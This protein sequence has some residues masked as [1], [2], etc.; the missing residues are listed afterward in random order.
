MKKLGASLAIMSLLSLARAAFAQ[1][2]N[3]PAPTP[4]TPG[5]E[6]PEARVHF[7]PEASTSLQVEDQVWHAVDVREAGL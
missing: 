5:L 7:H 6:G 3:A 2:G 4:R 1:D